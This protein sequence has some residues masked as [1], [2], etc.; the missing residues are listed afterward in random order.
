M[1][2]PTRFSNT[3][4]R[5]LVTSRGALLL[6][7]VALSFAAAGCGSGAKRASLENDRLRAE[8]LDL[9]DRIVGLEKR[10]AELEAELLRA[11]AEPRS[12]A[13]EY[14][15]NA[16]HVA[17]ISI[18]RLSHARDDDGDGRPDT[19]VL[20]VKPSD[21]LDRFV[22]MVGHL[23]AHAA[24]LPTNGDAVT[25]GRAN[26]G[27][28]E[29][30]QAYRSSALGTHYTVTLPIES[31]PDA[32]TTTVIAQVEFTDAYDGRVLTARSDIGLTQGP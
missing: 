22:Q 13:E 27:P 4:P 30:R 15:A 7:L 17:S 9:K 14:R 32:Q 24:I 28:A 19:L 21:G 3:G 6:T 20:Y 12:L 25:I 2:W 1:A 16:P 26:L 10:N 23:S 5:R 11:S 8:A 31:P 18:G 29:V